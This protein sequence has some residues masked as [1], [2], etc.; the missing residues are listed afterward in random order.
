M[1]AIL[2]IL[3]WAAVMATHVRIIVSQPWLSPLPLPQP[4]QTDGG[5]EQHRICTFCMSRSLCYK[6][7]QQSTFHNPCM[8][9]YPVEI[10]RI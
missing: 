10:E 6:H 8:K 7:K 2:H 5:Q 3:N 4:S 9:S 1:V